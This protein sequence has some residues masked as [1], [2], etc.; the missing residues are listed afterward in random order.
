MGCCRKVAPAPAQGAGSK[1][2]ALKFNRKQRRRNRHGCVKQY[3]YKP[4]GHYFILQEDGRRVNHRRHECDDKAIRYGRK[5]APTQGIWHKKPGA[6]QQRSSTKFNRK[7]KGRSWRRCVKHKY[8]YVDQGYRWA[9][10]A[11]CRAASSSGR[12]CS[13]HR[14]LVSRA[15]AFCACHPAKPPPRERRFA[16]RFPN[17]SHRTSFSWRRSAWPEGG[18]PVHLT[19][20]CACCSEEDRRWRKA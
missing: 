5:V 1:G 7:Q 12:D 10:T 17:P 3:P 13:N 14:S 16:Q 6:G 9:L 11:R 8:P 18:N 2:E 15:A 4:K 19:P 20:G